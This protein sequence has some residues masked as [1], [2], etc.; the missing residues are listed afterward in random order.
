MKH[1]M[2]YSTTK[3]SSA[4]MDI[5][6]GRALV[7]SPRLRSKALRISDCLHTGL[8]LLANIYYSNFQTC[9]L[10]CQKLLRIQELKS[11]GMAHKCVIQQPLVLNRLRRANSGLFDKSQD[12]NGSDNLNLLTVI[13]H[14]YSPSYQSLLS[15][16]ASCHQIPKTFSQ[17]S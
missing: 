17:I 11:T 1:T 15:S 8:Y 16:H 3:I 10:P 7:K 9:C 6:S 4:K 5:S 12:R 14:N 2:K 13:K